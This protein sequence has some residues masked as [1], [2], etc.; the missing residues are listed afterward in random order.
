MHA[1]NTFRPLNFPP[2]KIENEFEMCL[3]TEE[4]ASLTSKRIHQQ[5]TRK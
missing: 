4:P 3:E 5:R 1:M 2:L